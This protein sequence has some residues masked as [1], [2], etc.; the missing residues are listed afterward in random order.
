M[1]ETILPG[2]VRGSVVVPPS[3]SHTIR[4]V[5]IAAVAEGESRI[6]SP[7]VS[8]DSLS[9]LVACRALGGT[10]DRQIHQTGDE[11][12][13]INGRSTPVAG[14]IDVGN[15]GT[16]LFL[17]TP[18]A[19]V[20]NT[21]VR[22]TGDAQLLSRS[23][24]PLLSALEEL[25]AK[26]EFSNNGFP[27]YMV[28]GPLEGGACKI[29]S[30][31]SQF[32]S[33]LLL[34]APLMPRGLSVEVTELNERPYIE[35]TLHWL[36]RQGIRYQHDNLK[37][38]SIPGG[39]SY[40]CDSST[41]PGDY[42]SA[43]FLLCAAAIS[44]GEI[45]LSGLE[46]EDPQG[47]RA[48]VDILTLLGCKSWWEGETLHLR[49]PKASTQGEPSLKG[50]VI[51]LNAT[52]DALPAL[53]VTACY[54]RGT[55]RFVN[56]THARAKET[57]RI[58]VLVKE[59]SRLGARVEETDDGISVVGSPLEGGEVCGHGD[60]RIVMALSLAGLC[61]KRGVTVDTAEAVSIT[62]PNFF[63]LLRSIIQQ[64]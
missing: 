31:T 44:G 12:W 18:L 7:L 59:L 15:S 39:Q 60:H 24:A 23:A 2:T 54:A 43:T 34:A 14:E 13:I 32:L 3:K 42:S 26:V 36:D 17:S 16:T 62:F 61:S 9:S 50:A 56:V 55:T 37:W 48:I 1:K 11:V 8:D 63:N 52:P 27:P 35:M 51:D 46:R 33:G 40:R 6:V 29:S 49:G 47:D 30:P 19:A 22:F 5:L 41:I 28:S 21:P 20:G 4:A 45:A 64:E 10:V 38:F 25:G 57:D 58:S 53:A